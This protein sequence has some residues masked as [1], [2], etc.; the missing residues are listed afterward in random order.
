MKDNGEEN[1]QKYV[2]VIMLRIIMCRMYTKLCTMAIPKIIC[3]Y[4]HIRIAN[5]SKN[6]SIEYS[7][8][9]KQYMKQKIMFLYTIFIFYQ[10]K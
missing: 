5:Y 1:K 2:F 7:Q 10:K 6:N 8:R 3:F 9:K 4:L